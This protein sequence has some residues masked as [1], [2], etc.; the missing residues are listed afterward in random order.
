MPRLSLCL[1]VR[2]EEEMLPACLASVRGA[3]D[4]I[5]AADTGSTDGTR[6]LLV[7][8]G[9][10]VVDFPWCDDFAAARNAALAAA[11]G[12]HVLVLDA[13]ERLAGAAGE[14]LRRVAR[15][16]QLDCGLLPLHHASRLDAR[17]DEVLAGSARL[18]D[19]VLLPRLLRRAADLRWT[20]VVHEGVQDWLARPGR[21]VRTLDAPIVHYG[22]VPGWRAARH[23]H[24]RNLRLLE[25]RCRL[26]PESAVPRAYLANELLRAGD[27]ARARALLEDAV[28]LLVTARSRGQQV[29]PTQ[30]LTLR[31][32]AALKA[33]ELALAER[34]LALAHAWGCEHV[35]L[36]YLAAA[37]REH[38]S[39][40][41]PES[42]RRARAHEAAALYQRC[43]ARAGERS[44]AEVLPGATSYAAATALGHLH[45]WLGQP[46]DA[47]AAFE[48]ALLSSPGHLPARLGLLEARIELGDVAAALSAL[49]PLLGQAGPD[50]WFLA[51]HACERLGQLADAS[52]FATTSAREAAKVGFAA[53]HRAAALRRWLVA[54]GPQPPG[55]R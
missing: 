42:E 51:A 5:V 38:A 47:R 30:V 18:I 28:A 49:E 43:L 31:A 26:E 44:T 13:D 8:A 15:E 3:V 27:S 2:D 53:P 22:A 1:I 10:R 36:V 37:L 50:A 32:T 6:A 34:T 7:A 46:T 45:L 54:H 33:G 41:G 23:K 35:N 20:G 29:D 11:T 25:A 55:A 24:E 4:E 12:E 9:A 16:G 19:P 52:L 40:Q 17:P 39:L 21:V 14:I 48:R